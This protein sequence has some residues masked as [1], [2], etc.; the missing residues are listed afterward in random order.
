MVLKLI[1]SSFFFSKSLEYCK[2]N[3]FPKDRGI[4]VVDFEVW[5]S[6]IIV[7]KQHYFN[8][9]SSLSKLIC[10]RASTLA[11]IPVAFGDPLF[12]MLIKAF[13]EGISSALE[14][15]HNFCFAKHNASLLFQSSV[16]IVSEPC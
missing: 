5:E 1:L 13:S 9:P 3:I 14:M 6:W 7:R 12:Q 10:F 2:L 11:L 4:A 16:F 15:I 8:E